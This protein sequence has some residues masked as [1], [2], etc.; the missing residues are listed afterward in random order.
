MDEA[1]TPVPIVVEAC[2]IAD[3]E[4]AEPVIEA[5]F[6]E[7]VVMVADAMVAWAEADAAGAFDPSVSL[8]WPE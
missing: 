6:A 7:S 3:I 4:P 2:L 5:P 1:T 8:I